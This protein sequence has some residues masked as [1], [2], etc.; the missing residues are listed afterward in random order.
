MQ[1]TFQVLFL[2]I[3]V[4]V[5]VLG[6]ILG[7]TFA[8]WDYNTR[9]NAQQ[10]ELATACISGEGSWIPLNGYGMCIAHGK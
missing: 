6:V 5:V 1:D 9:W 2:T 10:K 8:I 4:V 7:I 3:A